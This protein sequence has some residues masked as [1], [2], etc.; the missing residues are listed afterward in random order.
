LFHVCPA[1]AF[2][3]LFCTYVPLLVPS[4]A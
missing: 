3:T 2:F 4:L 1:P